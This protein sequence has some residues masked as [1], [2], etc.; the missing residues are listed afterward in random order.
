MFYITLHA[1]LGLLIKYIHKVLVANLA[2]TLDV[3]WNG[4]ILVSSHNK[5]PQ[6]CIVFPK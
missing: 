3:I 2:I 5:F 4:V 1:T 6:I